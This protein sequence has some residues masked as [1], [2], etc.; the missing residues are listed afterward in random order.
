MNEKGIMAS[1][2][3]RRND[4]HSVV[5]RFK[6]KLPGVDAFTKEM[7]CIPVGW[8]I[9]QKDRKYIVQMIKAYDQSFPKT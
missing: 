7:V 2:V 6:K 5:S 9:R 3:H 4:T 1:Q 8:W